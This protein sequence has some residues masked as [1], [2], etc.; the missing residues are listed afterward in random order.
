M[1]D[2]RCRACGAPYLN[3]D[4]CS[5]DGCP[6]K[7]WRHRDFDAL[8]EQEPFSEPPMETTFSFREPDPH[9]G[10]PQE[11]GGV[12]TYPPMESE[13]ADLR[14]LLQDILRLSS[15]IAGRTGRRSLLAEVETLLRI[16]R[17]WGGRGIHWGRDIL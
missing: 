14:R 9:L 13:M 11:R 6:C 16:V 17:V 8:G 3:D 2:T 1:S 15:R 12:T 10:V 7:G 4:P 5:R